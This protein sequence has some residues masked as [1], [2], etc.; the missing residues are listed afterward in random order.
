MPQYGIW[1][2]R[3]KQPN[4][5]ES[6]FRDINIGNGRPQGEAVKDLSAAAHWT[7]TLR[8]I[9]MEHASEVKLYGLSFRR[10]SLAAGA[11]V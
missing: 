10:G 8:P 7:Q 4:V 2:C 3:T 6:V 9:C 11:R 5:Y 1:L